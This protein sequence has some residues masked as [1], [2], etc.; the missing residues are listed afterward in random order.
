MTK[1]NRLAVFCGASQGTKPMY[2]ETLKQLA[3][4]L[5]KSNIGLVYGGAR[6]G[7]MGQ[8]ADAMLQAGG[9]VIGVMPSFLNEKELAHDEITELHVV[10][11]MHERK[12]RMFELSDGFIMAPGGHGTLDEFFEMTTWGQLGVHKKPCGILNTANYFDHLLKFFDHMVSEEFL[13]PMY[14]NMLIVETSP[15]KLV[16]EFQHY[17]EPLQFKRKQDILACA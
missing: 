15:E 14:N 8:I 2:A 1:I 6:V 10:D 13:I 7:L 17:Q 9:E 16:H 5:A 12:E 4:L 11:S 3:T